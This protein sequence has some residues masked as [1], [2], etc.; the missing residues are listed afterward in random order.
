MEMRR[1]EN[2]FKLSWAMMIAFM[3]SALLPISSLSQG[4]SRGWRLRLDSLFVSTGGTVKL[5]ASD[6]YSMIGETIVIDTATATILA[7][8]IATMDTAIIKNLQG[9]TGTLSAESTTPNVSG[10]TMWNIDYESP[11][12]ITNIT[13]Q[14]YASRTRNIYFYVSGEE[15]SFADSLCEGGIGRTFLQGSLVSAVWK[16]NGWRVME[17]FSN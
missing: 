15:I 4:S 16:G 9:L 13:G 6:I 5:D 8:G 17:V 11:I 12:T 1:L 7:C 3:I 2:K 10:A 14:A